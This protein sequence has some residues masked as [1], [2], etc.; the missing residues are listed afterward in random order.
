MTSALRLQ[1]PAGKYGH[2][3]TGSLVRAS[4]QWQPRQQHAG[5]QI[6]PRVGPAGP[7]RTDTLD[8][9][10]VTSAGRA[11]ALTASL[12]PEGK[13]AG[14]TAECRFREPR[15]APGHAIGS[16]KA[17]MRAVTSRDSRPP[18]FTAPT[19]HN[20]D[21]A[22]ASCDIEPVLCAPRFTSFYAGLVY[23]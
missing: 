16:G 11:P 23:R 2:P 5:P 20:A 18:A 4:G 17:A 6:K 10:S 22:R 21:Y 15:P 13:G 19:T 3:E 7:V 14:G 1:P 9:G 8:P 12:G